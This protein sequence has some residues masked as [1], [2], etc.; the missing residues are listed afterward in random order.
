MQ[1]ALVE[2]VARERSAFAAILADKRG[3]IRVFEKGK[4]K[5]EDIE[6]EFKKFR[7]DFDLDRFGVMV[8]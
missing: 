3:T 7:K 5:R 6:Q 2:F 4:A 1:F 8:P